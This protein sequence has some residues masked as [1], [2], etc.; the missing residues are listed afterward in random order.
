[1]AEIK[2]KPQLPCIECSVV[3]CCPWY[4]HLSAGISSA[5]WKSA[6]WG[7]WRKTRS[8]S[9]V[10][11][12]VSGTVLSC[13]SAQHLLWYCHMQPAELNSGASSSA[14]PTHSDTV[15]NMEA[16]AY[17]S[18]LS[19]NFEVLTKPFSGCSAQVPSTSPLA[20]ENLSVCCR[21]RAHM[22]TPTKLAEVP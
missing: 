18:K 4:Q 22:P 5:M 11:I 16:L 2:V 8:R 6:T 14:G 21:V 20:S 7:K 17:I 19:L 12:S 3:L 13:V 15:L 10:Y 1:M 9:W